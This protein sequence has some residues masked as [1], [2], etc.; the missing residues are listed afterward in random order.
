[1]ESSFAV[2]DTVRSPHQQRVEQFMRLAGQATPD[3][4]MVPDEATRRLRAKL[5]LE[6]AL[7]TVEALGFAVEVDKTVRVRIEDVCVVPYG[8]P[9]LLQIV[10]GCCDLSVVTSG[11]LSSCGVAG[12]EPQRAVDEANLRKFGPGGHRREDGKWVKPSDWVP[13]LLTDIL[14]G[15][16]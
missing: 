14:A 7:E 2:R 16:L 11:T 15:Q 4:P 8:E 6:E 1:M 13:P 9:N 12:E 5:I 3:R 10:D